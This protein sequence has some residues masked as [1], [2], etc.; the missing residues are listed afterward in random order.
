M[1]DEFAGGLLHALRIGGCSVPGDVS[2]VGFDDSAVAALST[3]SLTT[4]G[5]D[6]RPLA[7]HTAASK[8]ERTS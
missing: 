3:V 7:Q 5:R 4:V 6:P 2:L 1:N 8:R